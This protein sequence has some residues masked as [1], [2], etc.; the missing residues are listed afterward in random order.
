M[1]IKNFVSKGLFRFGSLFL[2]FQNDYDFPLLKPFKDTNETML[3]LAPSQ[4]T[5][6]PLNAINLT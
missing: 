1:H 4:N 6:D 2:R 5:F 3:N